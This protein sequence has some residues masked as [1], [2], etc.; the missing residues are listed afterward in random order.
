MES[1]ERKANVEE[2][3]A[4][5]GE[6]VGKTRGLAQDSELW[7]VRLH[8]ASSPPGG[9][10]ASLDGWA[11]GPGGSRCP[12][13]APGSAELRPLIHH[14]SPA[15]GTVEHCLTPTGRT[16]QR[17]AELSTGG[18]RGGGGEVGGVR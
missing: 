15:G 6:S 3:S 5:N 13:C 17:D 14:A 12:P 16:A 8:S 4:V 2:T 9:L 11:P 10:W 18:G 7:C 1:A